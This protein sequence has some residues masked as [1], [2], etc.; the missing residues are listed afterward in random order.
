VSGKHRSCGII[1]A[2]YDLD[3][4]LA[5]WN[6]T[7]ATKEFGHPVEPAWLDR[8]APDHRILDY[9]CGYGRVTN[10]LRRHGF[11]SVEG[12]DTSP[13][14]IGR[15]R[16]SQPGT[17]F[18]LLSDPP[19][20]PHADA[21]VDAVMLF[22]VLTCVPTNEGQRELIAEL[23]RVLRPGGLLYVSD[24]VLQDDERNLAR[25]QRFADDYGVFGVFD[26]G[27]VAV[28]RHHRR[29]WLL[30]L[31]GDFAPVDEAAPK[32][33]TMNGHNVQAVQFLVART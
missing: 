10:I 23:H 6:S 8:L 2:M 19:R 31:L 7:G 9:G 4:Q 3:N 29:D 33:P 18:T 16:A 14:L 28:C 20:L 30:E 27:D 5:Y 32:V 12:V 1:A 17:R 15:A 11:T 26:T 24:I 22:A 13:A 25:Y 21:S